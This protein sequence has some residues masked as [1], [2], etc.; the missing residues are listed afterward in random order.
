MQLMFLGALL[1]AAVLEGIFP[2]RAV[3]SG[4]AFRWVN[5]VALAVINQFVFAAKAAL[6]TLTILSRLDSQEGLLSGVW[7]FGLWSG[8]I[9]ATIL[10]EFFGYL[11][12]R[13]FH[14]VPVL[15][16]IH[17]VHHSDTELDFSTALRAHPVEMMVLLPITGPFVLMLGLPVASL[18]LYLVIRI[19]LI[20]F[21]HSNIY[22]PPKVDRVLRY[23]IVTP[24]FHRMHHSSEQK[25]T[26]SNFATAF[27]WFD[28]L[29]GTHTRQPFE[30][31]EQMELGLEYFRGRED[32]RID[33]LLMC[34]FRWRR[35]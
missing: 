31:H 29:F 13:L 34:P 4:L 15:W 26:D 5:N 28:Y 35:S 20:T 12:H 7:D 27:P 9:V 2:R 6:V 3:S 11:I 18:I 33:H 24:D 10:L 23:L 8:L 25:Y 16:R 21:C 1:L 14:S 19:S 32:S 22:L 30:A 17:A